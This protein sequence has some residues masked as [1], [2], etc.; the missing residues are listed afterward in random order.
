MISLFVKFL[1]FYADFQIL[2]W[3]WKIPFNSVILPMALL[4]PGSLMEEQTKIIFIGAFILVSKNVSA[5]LNTDDT[6]VLN[7]N[8]ALKRWK[9]RSGAANIKK[10]FSEPIDYDVILVHKPEHLKQFTS[11]SSSN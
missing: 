3:G 5:Q 11:V 4:K 7:F 9:K 10:N 1:I 6:C 2:F 8:A